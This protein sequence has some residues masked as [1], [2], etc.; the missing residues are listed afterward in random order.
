[1]MELK[2]I[3]ANVLRGARLETST[4]LET[5]K[6]T[7]LLILKSESPIMIKAVQRNIAQE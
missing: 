1:M 4:K 3:I 5:M 7:P 2:A 6:L